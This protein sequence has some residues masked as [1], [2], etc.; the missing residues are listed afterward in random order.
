MIDLLDRHAAQLRWL[1][2][3]SLLPAHLLAVAHWYE[4]A[5]CLGGLAL[6]AHGVVA[7]RQLR[8]GH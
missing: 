8:C 6:L 5:M 4:A 2:E 3:Y 7:A 1:S